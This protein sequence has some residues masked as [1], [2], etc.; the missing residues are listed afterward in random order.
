MLLFIIKWNKMLTWLIKTCCAWS[1]SYTQV[2]RR[3]KNDSMIAKNLSLQQKSIQHKSL[4]EKW[5]NKRVHLKWISTSNVPLVSE[6]VFFSYCSPFSPCLWRRTSELLQCYRVSLMS[7]VPPR[8]STINFINIF[9]CRGRKGSK[10]S[11]QT[12]Y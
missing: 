3:P 2:R 5:D 7:S 11:S 9:I 12:L 10:S 6:N 8:I 1:Y 4:R